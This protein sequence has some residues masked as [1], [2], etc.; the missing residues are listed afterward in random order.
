[1][2]YGAK[3]STSEFVIYSGDDD[4]IMIKAALKA[5]NF[6]KKN[7]KFSAVLGKSLV[8]FIKKQFLLW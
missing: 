7:K 2:Y 6:L 1:M 8:F 5:A 3:K 4:F